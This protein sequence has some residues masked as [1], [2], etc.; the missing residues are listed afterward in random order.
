MRLPHKV[1]FLC[2]A[3]LA[4]GCGED[5]VCGAPPDTP[6]TIVATIGGSDFIL[7]DWKSS[8]NNDCGE[9]D[10][11][12][13]LT[14]EG[15]QQG[16]SIGLTLC[17]PRPDKLSETAVDVADTSL[18]RIID[19]FSEPDPGCTASLD[20][21]SDPIGTVGFPG[22]CGDGANPPGYALNFDLSVPMSVSCGDGAA[23][24]ESLT[25]QGLVQVEAI[26]F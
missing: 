7:A 2:S 10:G 1:L 3:V 18:V 15:I 24:S 4:G 14:V 17:L 25:L 20:R 11:P 12:T 13:S 9:P 6:T 5:A 19:I 23:S 16:T 26:V 8:P 22:I 21:S